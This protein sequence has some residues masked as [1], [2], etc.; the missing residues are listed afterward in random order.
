[1]IFTDVIDLRTGKTIATYS[2]LPVEAVRAAYAQFEQKDF[3][4]W[5]Y[6]KYPI[7]VGKHT[8]ACGNY[9]AMQKGNDR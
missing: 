7:T 2:C 4:T 1:M 6:K 3:C 8:V 5:E 9:C